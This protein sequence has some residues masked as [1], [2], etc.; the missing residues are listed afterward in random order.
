MSKDLIRLMQ[1]LFLPGVETAQGEPWR[2]NM[3]VYQTPEGWLVKFELAGVRPE[4]ID[5]QV[6]GRQMVLRG[7]RRD[8][9]R[10]EGCCYYQMEIAYS[11]FQRSLELPCDLKKTDI[12]TEYV[13]G[14]LL[15][16]VTII[17]EPYREPGLEKRKGAHS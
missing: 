17:A 5:L 3:D 13:A 2:P 1:A 12:R 9:T 7:V 8:S 14:M 6:L 4:D 15:V 10:P 11:R 16:H